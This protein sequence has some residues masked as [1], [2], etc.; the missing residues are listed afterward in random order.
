VDNLDVRR[1]VGDDVSKALARFSARKPCG[2]PSAPVV[3]MSPSEAPE[4]GASCDTVNDPPQQI[5]LRRR[6]RAERLFLELADS[7]PRA[8]ISTRLDPPRPRTLGLLQHGR[9]PPLCLMPT[10]SSIRFGRQHTGTAEWQV[11]RTFRLSTGRPGIPATPRRC[12][13]HETGWLG[14]TR[15]NGWTAT[16]P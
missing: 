1:C 10:S 2:R 12:R 15:R 4:R 6:C 13:H 3:F 11:Q 16:P 5:L 9:A 8:S 7:P 14:Q